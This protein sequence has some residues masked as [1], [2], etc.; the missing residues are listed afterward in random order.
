MLHEHVAAIADGWSGGDVGLYLGRCQIDT[1]SKLVAETW[2]RV[3]D[4]RPSFARVVDFGAGDGRFALAGK[5]DEYVGYELDRRRMGRLQ[6]PRGATVKH[7]C[8]F[9][10]M[11]EAA[12]L[13]IGNPPFVRNQDLPSGWRTQ[14]TEK[15]EARADV[16]LS[17][18]AN[19]W[20]YFFLQSLLSTKC[21]GVCALV[22]PYEWV[23]RPSAREVRDFIRRQS[24]HVDVYRLS[25]H[26]FDTVLTTASITIV[27][28]RNLDG[29]WRFFSTDASG[30]DHPMPSTSGAA[31]GH[32]DYARKP[33]GS[34]R[35]VRG[36][37]PGTQQ[38][39]TLTEGERARLGLKPDR[40]VLRCVTSLRKLPTDCSELDLQTFDAVYR[41]T[42]A[43][44]WLI[45]PSGPT[46][47][48]LRAYLDSVDPASYATA[49]C[50]E[51]EV[52]WKFVMPGTPGALI[53]ASIRRRAEHF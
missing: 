36:L 31:D 50:M 2:R 52:W 53:T 48:P 27:D 23:S 1:P 20:Q 32:I 39:L 45:N 44:C 18:L 9:S 49:T 11:S 46:E 17:G 8:A 10:N 25:D 40:D 3:H 15:L 14:V 47:G 51:R 13:C 24:W 16:R 12:D 42:G 6:L 37:S 29:E 26:S 43:R 33:A 4:L 41:S 22:I 30:Q 19:A 34:A 21:D 38:I 5:F 28:K 35:V 7:A